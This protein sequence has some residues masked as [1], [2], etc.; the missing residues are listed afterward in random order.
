M[1]RRLTARALPWLA[2][3]VMTFVADARAGQAVASASVAGTVYDPSGLVVPGAMVTLAHT[4]TNVKISARTDDRGEFRLASV[5]V[6]GYDLHVVVRGFAD[7][8]GH[9]TLTVGQAVDLPIKLALAAATEQVTVTVAAPLIDAARIPLA[10]TITPHDVD[11]LPLNGRNY[12]DL[13]LLAPNVSRT[14]T[15]SNERFAETSAVP[16]TGISVASQRNIGNTFIVDG[17]SAN[18]DAA[19]LAG[20]Y[21]SEEVI[22]EF[23]VVT[24]GGAAEFGRV[25]AG[26]VNIVTQS[27]AN[28]RRGRA[29]GFFRD[30]ALD[31]RNA[32]ATAEDPLNQQQYGVSYGGPVITDRTFWFAN[33]E[34]TNH[35]RTGIVTIS[36]VAQQAINATLNQVN[37]PGVRLQTGEF[38]TGYDTFNMFG[39]LD[40]RTSKG[41]LTLRYSLYDVGSANARNAGGLNDVSRGTR[42]EDRD[43]TFAGVFQAP[44]GATAVNEVRLQ[45]TRSRLSA[46]PNDLAGPAVNI[47]GVASFGTATF[48]P[49]A[50]DLD[51]L[52]AADTVTLQR[53]RHLVKAGADVILNRAGIGFPGALQG[54]YTFSSTAA[55]GR[56]EYITYQ[57]A[58][59]EAFTRQTNPN[60]GVFVQD[61]WRPRPSLT[62]NG[63]VRYDLQ[64][65]SPPVRL[66][67]NN[68][69]PRLG[70]AWSLDDRTVVRATGGI[71]FDRI[72]LRATAN[73]LQRDGSKYR[74][75]V[76][77]FGE[78]AAP[79]FPGVLQ[80]FP[81]TTLTA[82]AAIDP[83]VDSPRS[84]QLGVQ[85]ERAIGPAV[86]MS[87]AY[88]R[89]RGRGILMSRNINAPTLTA[90]EAL[91]LGIANLGRPN[92]AFGNISQ[93][94]SIGDS[95][96][97]G[98]T[99]T[100][101]ARPGTRGN[102][103]V[104]YTLSRALDTA[105][106]FFF[107]SPQDNADIAA[108]KGPSDNDQRHRLI[109]SGTLRAFW[110]LQFGY[111]VSAASGVPFNVQTGNDRN[112]D[113]NANDR[114]AGVGRNTGRQASTRSVDLR[115]SRPWV[116][117]DHRVEVMLEAFNALNHTNILAVNNVFGTAPTPRATFGQPT[118]AADPRQIQAGVRWGF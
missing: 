81:S 88:T 42:L 28:Q 102:A 115:I 77:S 95:W 114:P 82:I 104:S 105:G 76:L 25:S 6:G 113:T 99:V 14:N 75:A 5:P 93:Y 73:A 110:G 17:L 27:G 52:Q 36:P 80:A 33:V 90:A 44:L 118:L 65:L 11:T 61:E 20:T 54:V 100:L 40:D 71:Y 23:Q 94:E 16:G 112:G 69:S 59:G 92:P 26:I 22:R 103:R 85:I 24:A 51:L 64:W 55:F 84:E 68:V 97:D 58:F 41:M 56:G 10:S 74:V 3:I 39:R 66:D 62:V 46:P 8:R 49:T 4:G 1:E 107:S 72:P 32:L 34:R 50:R 48:S 21:F 7:V 31:A 35:D 53:G 78:T 9:F 43:Q 13:A 109:A 70:V 108:E 37:H 79:L 63:G 60:S 18:D 45:W 101:E 87:A 106:N 30:D 57:Q 83:D 91:A 2:A 111:L 67:A 12:L 89:L 117:G 98:F 15:R 47:S 96:F 29:Y 38:R 86:T 19:D 116:I